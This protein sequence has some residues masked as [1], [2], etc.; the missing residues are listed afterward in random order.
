[1]GNPRRKTILRRPDPAVSNARYREQYG[2]IV[3]C[4]D[5]A[6]QS[7]VYDTLRSLGYAC[8]VVVT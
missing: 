5:E 6:H 4:N 8:K 3:I 7:R 2:V 1:M